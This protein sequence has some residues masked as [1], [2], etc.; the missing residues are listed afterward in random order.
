MF[1]VVV[2]IYTPLCSVPNKVIKS[3]Q[4]PNCSWRT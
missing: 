4:E 1:C 3:N 2:T